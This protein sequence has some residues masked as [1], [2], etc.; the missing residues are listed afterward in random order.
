MSAGVAPAGPRAS[1]AASDAVRLHGLPDAPG[2]SSL[3]S[4]TL[5]LP[6]N[7]GWMPL[8]AEIAATP[9]AR[10]QGLTGR[11]RLPR[12]AG[13]LFLYPQDQ[14]PGNRFWMYRTNIP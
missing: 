8:T 13:M 4:V 12:R 2:D 1:C 9:E 10:R 3:A 11:E 5:C 7:N 6:G 14:G